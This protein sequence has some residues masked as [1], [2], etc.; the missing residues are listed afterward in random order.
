MKLKDL[1]EKT[2]LKILTNMDDKDVDGV[3]ISD[4]LSD[5]M[6]NAQAGNLWL[7]VQTHSNIVSAAN[8]IDVSAIVVTLGK[9]VSQKTI[10]LAN[11][12]HV[13]ILSS[14]ESSYNLTKKLIDAGLES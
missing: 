14:N 8:L 12:Y 1:I 7:T 10:D 3:F 9:E 11:R 4:M 6:A 5:V 13:V 2:G